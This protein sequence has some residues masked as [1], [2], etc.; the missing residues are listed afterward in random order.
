MSSKLSHTTPPG[1]PKGS[2]LMAGLLAAALSAGAA[3]PV[4][5]VIDDYEAGSNQNRFLGYSYFYADA[6]DG[7]TSVVTSSSPG[8]TASELLV[9]PAKSF[10]AGNNG[11][12]K[13]LKLDFTYGTNKPTCGAGCNYGQMVGF[14]T[15]LIAGT[16]PVGT[17]E[18]KVIDITGATAISFYAKA[19]EAMKVRVE[20]TTTAVKDFAF[21]RGEVTV[22]TAW[23]KHTVMLMP[24]LGGINQPSWTSTE[25]PFDPTTVQKLQFQISADDNATLTAGTLWLDDIVMEGYSWVPPSACVTCVSATP[26]TG[27]VLSDLEEVADPPRPA[28]QNAAG[29]FWYVFND[30]GSREVT[31]QSEYS[32]IFE[33]VDLTDPKVPMLQISPDKGAGGSGAA[34]INFTLGPSYKEGT[35]TVMPFVGIGTKTSN[36]LETN[37]WDATGSTGI[38]FDYWTSADAKF[39]FIRLEVKTNQTDLGPNPGVVHHVLVP[40][41]GGAWKTANIPWSKLVLPDWDEVPNKAAP[42]KISGIIKFQ[43]QVQ[44]APGTTGAFAI[45]NVKFPGLTAI[46]PASIRQMARASQDLRMTQAAG[47]L[48]VAVNL[49]SGV[50]NARVELV[51]LK[52]ALVQGRSLSGS[53]MVNATLDTRNLRGGVYVLQVR[54]GGTVRSMPVTLLK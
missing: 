39:Q 40:P 15:Q 44:D 3:T 20:I 41:T 33:G 22:S 16:D 6:A 49:P 47:R 37:S 54:N 13:S 26:A 23:E 25:L 1:L 42:V 17:G 34:Y 9:D 12:S 30:V 24:G 10:D 11:S 18:G 5:S 7:G 14:G 46:A 31:T 27:A 32:E 38:A 51:D 19:T 4:S 36:E 21:H 52:G 50:R 35:N 29:G 28:H 2:V 53:G 43:W 45:D 48:D 8:A